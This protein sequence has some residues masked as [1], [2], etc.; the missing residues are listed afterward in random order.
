MDTQP[1]ETTA[2]KRQPAAKSDELPQLSAKHVGPTDQ[3]SQVK[4]QRAAGATVPS[5]LKPGAVTCERLAKLAK[6]TPLCEDFST[7]LSTAA[8]LALL[9]KQNDFKNRCEASTLGTQFISSSVAEVE[10]EREKLA[11]REKTVAAVKTASRGCKKKRTTAADKRVVALEAELAKAI[12]V[13]ERL[14]DVAARSQANV[15]EAQ[16]RFQ[17][18]SICLGKDKHEKNWRVLTWKALKTSLQD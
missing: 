5:D 17:C 15:N 9:S 4:L 11:D 10:G 18:L 6:I 16:A 12:A 2:L 1:T 8:F 7:T 13:H 3:L 14:G